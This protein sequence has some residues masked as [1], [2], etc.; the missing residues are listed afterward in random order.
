MGVTDSFAAAFCDLDESSVIRAW[1]L[2]WS[3]FIVW[4]ACKKQINWLSLVTDNFNDC[5]ILSSCPIFP[6]R[7]GVNGYLSVMS[8]QA[9]EAFKLGLGDIAIHFLNYLRNLGYAE[10]VEYIPAHRGDQ[11]SYNPNRSPVYRRASTETDNC[12]HT[13]IHSYRHLQPN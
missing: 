6:V 11:A 8:K 2:C 5:F 10:A 3:P 7:S 12:T 1:Y 13:R 4:Y 9:V